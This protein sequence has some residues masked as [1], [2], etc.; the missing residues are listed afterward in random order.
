MEH[1][2]SI[3]EDITSIHYHLLARPVYSWMSHNDKTYKMRQFLYRRFFHKLYIFL[4]NNELHTLTWKNHPLST[5]PGIFV[6]KTEHAYSVFS[7]GI[8]IVKFALI[9]CNCTGPFLKL[10]LLVIKY[11]MLMYLRDFAFI[12]KEQLDLN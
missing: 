4:N 11:R 2:Q 9:S 3:R 7:Y 10:L 6:W 5:Q 8:A 12:V 1:N